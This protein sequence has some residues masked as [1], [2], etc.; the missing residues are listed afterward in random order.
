[1]NAYVVYTYE[2]MISAFKSKVMFELKNT[3]KS[4]VFSLSLFRVLNK[5]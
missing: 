5:Q 2:V 4:Q 1:M 3:N